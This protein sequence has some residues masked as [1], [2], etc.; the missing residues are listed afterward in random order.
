V[1]LLETVKEW[2]L[3]R[4][5]LGPSCDLPEGEFKRLTV[6]AR[7][8]RL[9]AVV[10]MK[11]L[12]SEINATLQRLKV[13]YIN[14]GDG[15]SCDIQHDGGVALGWCPCGYD[16]PTFLPMNPFRFLPALVRLEERL[17]GRSDYWDVHRKVRRLC[18]RMR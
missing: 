4:E 2:A 14:G 3:F 16:D 8:E 13:G 6:P 15:L 17:K 12:V 18:T 7:L 5:A 1:S 10:G 9:V 11:P